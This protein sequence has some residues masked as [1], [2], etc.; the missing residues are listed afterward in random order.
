MELTA[1]DA[2]CVGDEYDQPHTLLDWVEVRVIPASHA[3]TL[4]PR[5][6]S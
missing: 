1:V 5:V 3:V 2:H 6:S 4:S